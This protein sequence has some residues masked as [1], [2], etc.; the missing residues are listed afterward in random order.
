MLRVQSGMFSEIIFIIQYISRFK[1]HVN[2]ISTIH[3]PIKKPAEV[4]NQKTQWNEDQQGLQK[5]DTGY[6]YAR[7]F[8]EN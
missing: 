2:K 4:Q 8:R 7:Q 6:K 5:D 3:T 1:T